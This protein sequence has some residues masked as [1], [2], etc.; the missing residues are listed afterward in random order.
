MDL[1]NIDD[2]MSRLNNNKRLYIMLLKKFDAQGMLDDLLAK[3]RSGDAV[4]AEAQAHTIKGLAANLSLADLKEKA[5]A[6]DAK[7][8]TGDVGVDTSDIILSVSRT[9]EAINVWIAANS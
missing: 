5:E 7:L 2:A 9:V 8:K 4:A 6:A 1:M 3:I